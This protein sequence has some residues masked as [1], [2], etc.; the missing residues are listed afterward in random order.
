MTQF[1]VWRV[2]Q[3]LSDGLKHMLRGLARGTD[4]EDEAMLGFVG[5]VQGS[6]LFKNKRV[7]V[8]HGCCLLSMTEGTKRMVAEFGLQC[9]YKIVIISNMCNT[10][11]RLTTT[12]E[13]QEIISLTVGRMIVAWIKLLHACMAHW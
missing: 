3:T 5:L 11:Y 9:V 10:V 7:G 1:C 2:R 4:D 6:K 13:Q 12:G 8:R